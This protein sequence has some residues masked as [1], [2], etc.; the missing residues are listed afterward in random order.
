MKNKN[1]PLVSVLMP[2]YNAEDYIG[3]A[4]GSILNQTYE[5]FEFLI[6]DDCSTDTTNRIIKRYAKKDKRIKLIKNK[7]NL[8]VALSLNSGLKVCK[9][10]YVVRMDSDD[11]SYP[12][13]IEKQ[14]NFMEDNLDVAVSGGATLVCDEKLQPLGVR[15]YPLENSEIR[16]CILRLNPIPHPASIWR[17]EVLLK[18]KFYPRVAK[19]EDYALILELS[20]FSKLANIADILLKFRVHTK[21]VSNSSIIQQQKASLYLFNKAVYEYG[22]TPSTK[23]KMWRLAQIV[24][25]YTLP[26]KLKRSLLNWLVLDRDISKI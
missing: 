10:K 8:N 13:R 18:T 25:M 9:G 23:D 16:E 3:D 22:Y 17:K 15:Y 20:S 11:W 21:S 6:V 7:V 1:K 2:A 12:E 4:I 5:N 26:P 19:A 14:V 24:S